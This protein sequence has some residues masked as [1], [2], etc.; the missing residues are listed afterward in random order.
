MS[1]HK[2]PIW[3]FSLPLRAEFV[4]GFCEKIFYFFIFHPHWLG[5]YWAVG[6]IRCAT[7]PFAPFSEGGAPKGRGLVAVVWV[8]QP[9]S[10][11]ACHPL[12]RRGQRT[13]RQSPL[14]RRGGGWLA[15]VK[16]LC[17]TNACRVEYTKDKEKGVWPLTI[18]SPKNSDKSNRNSW[19]EY[20]W[21]LLFVTLYVHQHCNAKHRVI[22]DDLQNVKYYWH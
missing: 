8:A 22:R 6:L 15:V 18:T 11:Y 4:K 16:K 10:R 17:L 1:T 21:R 3:C 5:I 19:R 20:M 13:T 7:L 14:H 9:P 2:F 12:H